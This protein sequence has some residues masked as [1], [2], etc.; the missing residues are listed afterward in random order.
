MTHRAVRMER[1][2]RENMEPPARNAQ[3][4][5]T[6]NESFPI[7]YFCGQD[8]T[9]EFPL[10]VSTIPC[11]LPAQLVKQRIKFKLFDITLNIELPRF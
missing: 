6:I 7:P 8:D 5:V 2:L 11:E 4:L 3:L 10:V 9:Y 1:R